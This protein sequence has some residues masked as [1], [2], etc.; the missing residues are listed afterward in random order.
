MNVAQKRKR[1][2]SNKKRKPSLQLLEV[3]MVRDGG[4]SLALEVP[5]N[6]RT[7]EMLAGPEPDLLP[8]VPRAHQ[9]KLGMPMASMKPGYK[10]SSYNK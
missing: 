1:R 9:G 7:T 3:A 5:R 2:G 6:F 10:V 4:Y 8:C